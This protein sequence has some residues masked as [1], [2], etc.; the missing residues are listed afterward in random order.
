MKMKC[1]SLAVGVYSSSAVFPVYGKSC[2]YPMMPEFQYIAYSKLNA[3]Q[4]ENYNFHHLAA[5]LASV[6][7]NSI[8]LSDD[9]EGADLIAIPNNQGEILKIQLKGRMEFHKKYLGKNLYI[10]FPCDRGKNTWYLYPHDELVSIYLTRFEKT[11]SWGELTGGEFYTFP[12]LTQSDKVN[13]SGY[14]IPVAHVDSV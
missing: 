10:A 3:R 11:A 8:R 4:K 14:I 7:F 5:A 1:T 6:G 12:K 2:Y 13:L 9:Y